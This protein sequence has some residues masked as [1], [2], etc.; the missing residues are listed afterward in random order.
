MC[1]LD[2][3]ICI[4]NTHIYACFV[5]ISMCVLY[6]Y[7]CVF[8][9]HIHASQRHIY[10]RLIKVIGEKYTWDYIEPIYHEPNFKQMANHITVG[11]GF[12]NG[13]STYP[14]SKIR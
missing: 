11:N 10:M 13:D 1:V 6:P 4:Q 8:C 2:A 9:T 12:V 5:R 14:S 7:I 3:C